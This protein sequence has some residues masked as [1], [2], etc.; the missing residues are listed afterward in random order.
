MC[1]TFV[2]WER[3]NRTRGKKTKPKLKSKQ[4]LSCIFFQ[5]FWIVW[6]P[7]WFRLPLFW[8]W[9]HWVILLTFSNTLGRNAHCMSL[10]TYSDNAAII[11]SAVECSASLSHPRLYCVTLDRSLGFRP[12]RASTTIRAKFTQ[13]TGV[14]QGPVLWPFALWCLP[15]NFRPGV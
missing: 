3:Q 13:Q 6:N 12:R 9:T 14:Q 1:I 10:H 11:C 8:P 4:K 2:F 7:Q 5:F 15:E